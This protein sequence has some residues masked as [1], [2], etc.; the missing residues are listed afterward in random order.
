MNELEALARSMA[1]T[2]K[3]TNQHISS[4][5]FEQ[6]TVFLKDSRVVNSTDAFFKKFIESCVLW[7]QFQPVIMNT[8][9]F[10][11]T[12]M[13]GV[14]PDMTIKVQTEENKVL[15]QLSQKLMKLFGTVTKTLLLPL[16]N[17]SKE[18]FLKKLSKEF[19]TT[20]FVDYVPKC[21]AFQLEYKNRIGERIKRN[22]WINARIIV[23]I[24][25]NN[26]K[27]NFKDPHIEPLIR[28][29]DRLRDRLCEIQDEEALNELDNSIKDELKLRDSLILIR[30]EFLRNGD[31]GTFDLIE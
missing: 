29:I 13:L 18:K 8:R 27:I 10:L 28:E 2:N 5:S 9:M 25:G 31:Q 23:G 30:Q 1:L 7:N 16:A 6:M 12:F 19:Y 21:T 4:L 20:F 11:G 26:E 17:S 3:V 24:S 14:Y 22:V 15:I